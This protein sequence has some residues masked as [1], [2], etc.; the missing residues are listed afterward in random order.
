MWRDGYSY[1]AI[2]KLLNL[3]SAGAAERVVTEQR[4]EEL[5]RPIPYAKTLV[6]A[7]SA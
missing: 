3:F 1:E 7:R 2:A 6:L 5:R 4:S